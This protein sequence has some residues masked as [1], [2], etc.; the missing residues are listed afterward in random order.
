MSNLT[1]RQ[2][3]PGSPK[4]NIIYKGAPLSHGELDANFY[5]L[6]SDLASGV[7]DSGL[8]V[9]EGILLETGDLELENGNLIL[10]NGNIHY[11]P[12]LKFRDMVAAENRMTLDSNGYLLLGT[13]NNDQGVTLK[14]TRL[15]NQHTLVGSAVS[16]SGQITRSEMGPA[17]GTPDTG[18]GVKATQVTSNFSDWS[19]T[20]FSSNST[21]GYVDGLTVNKDGSTNIHG[22][23]ILEDDVTCNQDLEVLGNLDVSG[24]TNLNGLDVSGNTNIGGDLNV[25]GQILN[26]GTPIPEGTVTSVAMSVPT[27]LTVSGS[28]ITSSGT[29]ALAM[30]S[31]YSIPLSSSQTNWN[32]AYSWG[33]HST[34]GYA[35]SSTSINTSN[36]IQGGGNLTTDRSL[37]LTGSYSGTWSVS[38][39][40]T[41]TGDVTA[42]SDIALKKDI[43]VIDDALNKVS[44]L[45]GYIFSRK[46]DDSRRYTGVMAQE[47]KS[48]LPEAV[49]GEEGN[50]S[51]A[52]GNMV[53]LLVEAI[54]ELRKEVEELKKG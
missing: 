18:S 27:G 2:T 29:L 32:T 10:N 53:G 38:G 11:N 23:T 9:N 39:Q 7:F 12:E 54:K 47:V 21:N 43:N 8:F 13:E 5:A 1:L 33:D 44:K 26:G 37:S 15:G 28:P 40:I 45:G 42:F 24:N 34:A 31:G 35:S 51:V 3:A 16:N 17:G 14:V 19:V 25:L 41:A 48:V 4:P 50:Y 22:P 46:D 20:L 30:Q 49:H 6:D 36:G 52:Y